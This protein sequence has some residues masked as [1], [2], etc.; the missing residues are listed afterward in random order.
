MCT[1]Y[2]NLN[3]A[4][5]KDAYRLPSIENLMDGAFDFQ[6]LSFLGAYSRYN[7]I[8]MHPPYEDDTTF[9]IADANFCYRF[10][11]FGLKNPGATYQWLM[12]QVFKH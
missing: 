5:P 2:T 10:M 4:H 9:I 11:P 1:D 12:D 3:K 7:Q 8:R 6:L